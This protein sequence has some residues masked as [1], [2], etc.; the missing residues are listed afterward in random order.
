MAKSGVSQLL[1]DKWRLLHKYQQYVCQLSEVK[2]H[3]TMCRPHGHTQLSFYCTFTSGLQILNSKFTCLGWR[4][5]HEQ[6]NW[7]LLLLTSVIQK[8]PLRNATQVRISSD[9]F[10]WGNN[11]NFQKKKKENLTELEQYIL[12]FVW[13]HRWLQMLKATLK[14]KNRIGGIRFP[15][16]GLYYKATIIKIVWYWHKNR[17]IDQWNRI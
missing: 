1:P 3:E 2:P 5:F 6:I 17:N 14:R 7:V 9:L 13:K 15:G 16:F 4:L 11:W 8:F 10:L 12:K